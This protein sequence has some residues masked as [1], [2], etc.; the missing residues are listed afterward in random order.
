MA[1]VSHDRFEPVSLTPALLEQ[2]AALTQH[3]LEPMIDADWSLP[4]PNLE[5]SCWQ[6][7]VHMADGYFA[8]ASQV[9]AR[10][11]DGFLPAEVIVDGAASPA[12]L[13]TIIRTCAGMLAC[14]ATL[15]DPADRSWH[16][17]GIAD[18]IGSVAMGVVEGLVHTWDIATGLGVDWHPPADLCEPVLDRLFPDAPE[19][20]PSEVLLWC[21]GRSALPDLARQVEWRW[22]CSVR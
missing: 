6:T 19:G 2:T 4:V 5:W 10:P 9:L 14:A 15:A 18:P 1:T 3:T 12:Q 16:P 7:G 22:Y 21:T 11:S 8:H 13:L 20:D 17:W